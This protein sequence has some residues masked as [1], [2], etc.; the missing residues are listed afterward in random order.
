MASLV[1]NIVLSDRPLYHMF[2]QMSLYL[3]EKLSP[4]TIKWRTIEG[5]WP[6]FQLRYQ[7]EL[8]STIQNQVLV[9]DNYALFFKPQTVEIEERTNWTWRLHDC[10]LHNTYVTKPFYESNKL[11]VYLRF[12]RMRGTFEVETQSHSPV[13]AHDYLVT[14]LARFNNKYS[15]IDLFNYPIVIP[16]KLIQQDYVDWYNELVM[17]PQVVY[18]Y[19]G[20]TGENHFSFSLPL[21]PL[22]RLSSAP[23]YS[24][25]AE[26][27]YSVVSSFEYLVSIPV[28]LIWEDR[29]HPIEHVFYTLKYDDVF[30]KGLAG[31]MNVDQE[32]VGFIPV[33]N[34][35]LTSL[36][37]DFIITVPY[38][39]DFIWTVLDITDNCKRITDIDISISVPDTSLPTKKRIV[40]T[41]PTTVNLENEIYFY[42]GRKSV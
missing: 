37:S 18:S 4:M 30:D 5:F 14:T 8:L 17:S 20:V 32:K 2:Y 10:M 22:V 24:V 31:V 16:I 3:C 13:F 12:M 27:Q 28:T 1:T 35:R 23:S 25:V 9:P 6:G 38:D 21:R 19:L 7:Q 26:Q 11:R 42:W 36:Q 41:L 29:A 15:Y 40:L 34:V 39:T 33:G